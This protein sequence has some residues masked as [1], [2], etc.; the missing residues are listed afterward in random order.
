MALEMQAVFTYYNAEA[1][2]GSL[3]VLWMVNTV[4]RRSLGDTTAWIGTTAL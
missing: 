1:D 4:Y 3:L 2:N